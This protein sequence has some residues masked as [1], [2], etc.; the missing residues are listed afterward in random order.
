MKFK[1]CYIFFVYKSLRFE[2]V[3]LG[4]DI[5]SIIINT[6]IITQIIHTLTL[7]FIENTL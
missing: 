6:Q 7:C 3:S 5:I 1:F 2:K 4:D